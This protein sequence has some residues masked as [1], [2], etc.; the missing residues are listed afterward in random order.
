M[1]D[2]QKNII[3]KNLYYK[4][5]LIVKYRIEYPRIVYNS[6]LFSIRKF[7]QFNQVKA[8]N[9]KLYAEKEL[10]KNAQELFDYNMSNNYPFS[11]YELVYTFTPTYN[12]SNIISLYADEYV[13][14]GGA[15]GSTI[16]SSQNWNM[17]TGSQFSLPDLFNNDCLYIIYILKEIFHQIEIQ[18]ENEAGS[19]FENYAKLAVENFQSNQFYITDDGI[20]I[21]YQ[22]YDIAP[23]SS[24]IPVFIINLGNS[25]DITS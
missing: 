21:F 24:G 7:N 17:S 15:H 8:M 16:R 13:Y 22:Q 10:F 9:L 25:F 4:N 20:A 19:Y 6:Y 3:E 11:P 23:Y 5:N 18:I 1:F 14:A 2:I 12:K